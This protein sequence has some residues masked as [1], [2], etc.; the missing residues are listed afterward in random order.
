MQPGLMPGLRVGS[1][2]LADGQ[3]IVDVRPVLRRGIGRI[4]AERLDG[5]DGLQHLLDLGPPGNLQQTF[6]AGAHIGHGDVALARHDGAQDVDARYG[7]PVIVAGPADKGEN[8]PR[9]KRYDAPLAVDD[10]LIDDPTEADPVLDLL[11]DPP[12]PHMPAFGPSAPRALGG[13]P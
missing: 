10:M 6:A 9:L 4:D 8:A 1:G 11:P 2:L 5:I 7:G 3:A 12:E 13:K